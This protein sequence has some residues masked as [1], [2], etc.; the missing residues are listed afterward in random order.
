M[1]GVLDGLSLSECL[2]SLLEFNML[3]CELISELGSLVIP[4]QA[5]RTFKQ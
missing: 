2:E 1:M 3:H 5:N 4:D